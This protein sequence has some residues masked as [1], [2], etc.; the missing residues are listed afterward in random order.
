MSLRLPQSIGSGRGAGFH[1]HAF[2]VGL[3]GDGEIA[4]GVDFSEENAKGGINPRKTELRSIPPHYCEMNCHEPS[5]HRA[6]QK[7]VLAPTSL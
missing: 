7:K 1:V 5:A 2:G 4:L 3:E 6:P